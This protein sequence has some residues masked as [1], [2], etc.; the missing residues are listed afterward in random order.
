MATKGKKKLGERRL[1]TAK[2]KN[3]ILQLSGAHYIFCLCAFFAFELP[4]TL[5]LRLKLGFN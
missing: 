5:A 2:T 3:K 1:V 4:D